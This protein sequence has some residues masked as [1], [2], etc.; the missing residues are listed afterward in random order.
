M[1]DDALKYSRQ[2]NRLPRHSGTYPLYT[3]ARLPPQLTNAHQDPS[4]SCTPEQLSA[5]ETR[6][7]DLRNQTTQLTATAKILR[8][9]LSSLN[10]SLSTA[11]L[12][13]NVQALESEK[14]E[15]LARLQS[16]KE[17]KAKKVTTEQREEVE[18]EWKKACS[19]AKRR[20]KV[21]R[22]VWEYIEDQVQ[23]KE[24]R[25]ELREELGLDE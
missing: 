9:S 18:K 17:G 20:E 24:A 2:A 5:I 7:T 12:V 10:S 1:S 13:A 19:V 23:D 25:E 11:D 4:E 16:L 14:A 6:I 21:A 15:I 3:H 8:S 22:E